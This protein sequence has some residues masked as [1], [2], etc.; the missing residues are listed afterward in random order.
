MESRSLMTSSMKGFL[1][2][3]SFL[4]SLEMINISNMHKALSYYLQ[5]IKKS[6]SYFLIIDE[7]RKLS[8]VSILTLPS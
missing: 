8:T 3:K 5:V 7:P 6:F 2:L 1:K 4:V